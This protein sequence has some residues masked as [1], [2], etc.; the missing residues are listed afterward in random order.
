MSVAFLVLCVVGRAPCL[1]DLLVVVMSCASCGRQVMVARP[2]KCIYCNEC[3]MLAKTFRVAAE[4][5][6]VVTV[7]PNE[8][9]FLFTVEVRAKE[10]NLGHGHR[11]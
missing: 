6:S 3:V 8:E 10:R 11:V 1:K 9:R 5:D 2:Q 7:R 4:D